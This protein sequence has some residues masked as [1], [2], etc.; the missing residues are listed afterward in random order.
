MKYMGQCYQHFLPKFPQ[1]YANGLS[2]VMLNVE[3]LLNSVENIGSRLFLDLKCIFLVSCIY[4]SREKYV[5]PYFYKAF[6][7]AR[8]RKNKTK[9][10]L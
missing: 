1:N 8:A 4:Q 7:L 5:L 6:C 10:T 2:R 3:I 9:N